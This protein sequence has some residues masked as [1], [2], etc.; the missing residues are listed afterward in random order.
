MEFPNDSTLYHEAGHAVIALQQGV[1]VKSITVQPTAN[2]LG[3]TSHYPIGD[4]FR[5]DVAWSPR[6]ADRIDRH[7]RIAL[8][9]AAAERIWASDRDDLPSHWEKAAEQSWQSDMDSAVDLALYRTRAADEYLQWLQQEVQ[10]LL[11]AETHWESVEAVAAALKI[12]PRLTAKDIKR[13]VLETQGRAP[14]V[15]LV[16]VDGVITVRKQ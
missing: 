11:S 10:L 4:W 5:P 12:K 6:V 14:Q 2:Y 3:L 8:A 9:G 16:K 13:I 15:D 1:G 7:V